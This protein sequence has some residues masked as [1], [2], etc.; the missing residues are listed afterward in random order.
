MKVF[1]AGLAT[2]T[3]SFSP[4]PTRFEDFT[5]VRGGVPEGPL[6]P[7][8][9]PLRVFREKTRERGWQ[10]VEGLCAH[11]T[12]SGPTLQGTY[13][14]LRDEIL[15]ALSAALPVDMVLLNLHGS[16]EAERCPD[17]EGDLLARMRDLVGPEVPI[18]AELDLHSHP[19][20]KMLNN[21]TALIIYKEW[22]HIDSE[23]RAAELFE[24]IADAA[25]GKSR[26]SM[27]VFNTRMLGLYPTGAEP[28]RGFVAQLKAVEAQAGVLSV[29]LAHDHIW[30]DVPEMGAHLLVVTDQ[31]PRLG[32]SIAREL[33][34]TFYGLRE[35]ASQRFPSLEEGLRQALAH[36]KG[37]VV[38]VDVPDNPGGGAPGD[39]TQVLQ[40]LLEARA[41]AAVMLY[42]PMVAQLA[43]GAGPGAS[44]QVRLGGKSG[45][46]SGQPLDL[47][48]TVTAVRKALTQQFM[49]APVS[50]GDA[51][52][53]RCGPVD[54]VV[55]SQRSATNTPECY[56][57]LGIN[58]LNKKILVAKTLNN[59]RPGFD[60]VAAEY[61]WVD[62][63]GGCC[64][65]DPRE[66][67]LRHIEGPMWPMVA[68]PLGVGSGG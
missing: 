68:D 18:G 14:R 34:L 46:V 47:A 58:P 54:I 65:G 21:A 51:V 16:M 60:S 6:I 7:F 28:M 11:A 45:R 4:L 59:C 29:S 1:T 56:E 36:S 22:P 38:L 15:A 37:P 31:Q 41:D 3:N 19:T 32:E 61:I 52:A 67:G 25:L 62:Y 8:E 48:V 26:P 42:D 53:L 63:P 9:A 12:P 13:E 39:G 17:T 49:G 66:I 57:K 5:I 44:L 33:G 43:A 55:L 2:E 64:A 23:A 40:A 24:I 27:S 30:T 20:E 50:M 35:A 10:L